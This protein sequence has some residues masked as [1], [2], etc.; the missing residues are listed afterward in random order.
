M[1]S[2]IYSFFVLYPIGGSGCIFAGYVYNVYCTVYQ[3]ILS[4]VCSY[5]SSR[6]KK[7]KP[8]EELDSVVG[9]NVE[10]FEEVT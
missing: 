10:C 3:T 6:V 8:M 7:L 2:I 4:A 9:I 5:I 1:T